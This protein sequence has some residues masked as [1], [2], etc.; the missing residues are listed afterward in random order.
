MKSNALIFVAIAVLLLCGT[1][2]AAPT[3]TSYTNS[4]T[5]DG[6]IYPLVGN[7]VSVNFSIVVSEAVTGYEWWIDDATVTN[8]EPYI[9]RS[10]TDTYY[11]NVTVKATTATGE[12]SLTWFPV[13]ERSTAITRTE[14]IN[15]TA[16]DNMMDSLEGDTDYIAFL[17]AMTVPFTNI[18]GAM[19]YV[20]IWG[21]Y[22]GMVWI[23]QESVYVPSIVGLICGVVLF[24]YLP[25]N[26]A[27][28][29]TSLLVLSAASAIFNLYR[30][31]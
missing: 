7:G 17:S 24:V 13:V 31:R 16:Y 14:T 6:D 10:W 4:V 5:N 26:F 19:F 27:V 20:L 22:F 23:R 12:V 28:A 2:T 11:H 8:D 1:A 3:I 15:G 9:F 18:I 21:F 25:S 29:G 30:E